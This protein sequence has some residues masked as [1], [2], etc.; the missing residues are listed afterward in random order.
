MSGVLSTAVA[1]TIPG[2]PGGSPVVSPATSSGSFPI[3][4]GSYPISVGSGTSVTSN[5]VFGLGSLIEVAVVVLAVVT[6]L[7]IVGVLVIVVV[8]NRADPDPTGRRP[9]SVYFFAVSFVTLIVSIIGSAAIVTALVQL[10]GSHAGETNSIARVI[11]LGGLI[12]AVSLVLLISHLRR[13]VA[14]ANAG[15][16]PGN[17]SRRVGQSYTAAVAF[18]SVLVLLMAAVLSAY[19]IFAL[20]GPG[21]FGSF[22]GTTP[23]LR[24]LVVGLYLG[25]IAIVVLGTHRNLVPPG[26]RLLGGAEA[27]SE[28]PP[29]DTGDPLS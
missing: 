27:G 3:S 18:V 9:Q 14:L 26:L 6:L 19:L 23:A 2:F 24:Y 17:P 16:S 11:V 10:I 8:S 22:G 1:T 7:A 4:S 5:Q 28:T 12:T 20:A 29:V 21:V 15:Q 13:G 25:L